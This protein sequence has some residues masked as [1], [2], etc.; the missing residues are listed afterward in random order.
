MLDSPAVSSQP[1]P[2]IDSEAPLPVE[3]VCPRCQQLS[4][5][6]SFCE[7]CQSEFPSQAAAQWS[8][9]ALTVAWPDDPVE[10]FAVAITPSSRHRVRGVRPE[11]WRLLGQNIRDRAALVCSALPQTTVLEISGGA[12]LFTET[13]EHAPTSPPT[14]EVSAVL[15]ECELLAVAMTALHSV[16]GVWFDFDPTAIEV[17]DGQARITNLDWRIVR[18][19]ECPEYS[20]R[21]SP[22]YS[23]PEV[24]GFRAE[25]IGTATDVFHLAM[26][27]YYRLAGL[28]PCGFG[29]RGLEAFDFDVPTLRVFRRDLPC[30]I[31]PVLRRAVS[32]DPK[33]RPATPAELMAQLRAC[34]ER[35]AAEIRQ[36]DVSPEASGKTPL[37]EPEVIVQQPVSLT[38][39]LLSWV[40]MMGRPFG[41]RTLAPVTAAAPEHAA[42]VG[43]LTIAGKLKS[44]QGM[45]N[46]DVAD[47]YLVAV[48]SDGSDGARSRPVIIA[49]VADGV[50]T[51]RVG[52]GDRASLI[53]RDTLRRVI[54]E[55]C[56]ALTAG[57]AADWPTILERACLEASR[58]I[59]AA[60]IALPDWP[61][62]TQDCDLMSTTALL[63]VL[64]GDQLHLAN[65][66]D[67]R[68]YIVSGD[69]V[70]QLTV[71]GDVA[72]TK[73]ASGTPPEDVRE[74]GTAGKAL[75]FC[76]GAARADEA[77]SFVIEEDRC[78]P[79]LSVWRLNPDDIVVLCS[80][81]LVEERVFLEPEELK[82]LVQEGRECSAQQLAE[83]LVKEADSR[84]RLPSETEPNG[85][86]DNISCVVLRSLAT[87]SQPATPAQRAP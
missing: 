31:W 38:A 50:S 66:G 7:H 86:G 80:D 49:L 42:N 52:S 56:S 23:P 13:G 87:S 85:C 6:L 84:Q 5:D 40:K 69:V 78:R 9:A 43:L 76:L 48:P 28:G 8:L 41:L 64:D 62:Q 61:A 65:V 20:A 37:G 2:T 24:C 47:S 72:M 57:Q 4:R 75:R 51:A 30:G 46:Q 32:T 39:R 63:A 10:S 68:A 27:A 53:A 59:L 83:S 14:N 79:S 16:G 25:Q 21:V 58:D 11:L 22:Q 29:G 71:D 18:F 19:G 67:S 3:V 17:R 12:L 73:L 33:Q 34:G 55:Q 1:L 15:A 35:V 82:Q 77:G 44:L 60:A 36:P 26:F 81:G 45:T 74:L 70:D 54:T